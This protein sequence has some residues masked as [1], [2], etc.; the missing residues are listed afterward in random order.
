M[1]IYV[2]TYKKYNEGSLYGNWFDLE[3]YDDLYEFYMACRDFHNDEED[4][5]FMFQDYEEIPDNL[6]GESWIDQEIY[7]LLN[8]NGDLEALLSFISLGNYNSLSDYI[9]AFNYSYV[10]KLESCNDELTALGI[11]AAEDGCYD[12]PNELDDI[13]DYEK[14]GAKIQYDYNIVNGYL[15]SNY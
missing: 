11:W 2:S 3:D 8:F 4:P 7:Q 14:I 10:T 9:E 1:K 12:I 6:I 15:F 5:E 13:V